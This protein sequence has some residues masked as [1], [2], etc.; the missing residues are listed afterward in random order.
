MP[1]VGK[2]I[3]WKTGEVVKYLAR[4]FSLDNG[5]S[6]RALRRAG[7]CLYIQ[8]VEEAAEEVAPDEGYQGEE[9]ADLD[10]LGEGRMEAPEWE[11]PDI[12]EDGNPEAEDHVENGLGEGGASGLADGETWAGLRG[13]YIH[14][15][16]APLKSAE[17]GP[18]LSNVLLGVGSGERGGNEREGGLLP[19]DLDG[20][21]EGTEEGEERGESHHF[22]ASFTFSAT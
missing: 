9:E 12:G 6:P 22:L 3:L 19:G 14:G 5:A 21:E 8:Q 13:T 7:T 10:P 11:E 17:A 1:P 18:E 4:L 15:K 2:R 20:E 16:G